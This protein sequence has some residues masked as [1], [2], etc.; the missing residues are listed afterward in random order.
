MHSRALAP[1]AILATAVFAA[2]SGSAAA[3]PSA[4]PPTTRPQL[5]PGLTVIGSPEQA[6]TLPGSAA[7]IATEDIRGQSYADV[8]RVLR[9]VPGV[10]VREE[11][12]FGLFPNVSLRG[13]DTTRNSKLTVME[14]GVLTAP[15]PYA[16][17]AAY[18]SPNI[19]RMSA[20]EIL[21]G[22]SQIR[23]GPHTTGGVIN[24]LSTAI[25]TEP[26][27]YV[28]TLY[29]QRNEVRAHAYGGDTL[30]TPWGHLGLL[31]EGFYRETDGFKHIDL[32][33]DFRDG[34]R[35]GFS[36]GEP[37]LKLAFEPSAGPYQRFEFKIG[38]SDLDADETYLGLSDA[39]FRA[40]SNR[41]YAASRFD[42]IATEHT[43]TYLRHVISPAETIRL[44]T[45]AY[46]NEFARNWFKLHDIAIPN[47]DDEGRTNVSLS[48]AL[49]GAQDGRALAVLKGDAAG[50][51]RVRNND[52]SY[53]LY[54]VENVSEVDVQ[55]G[56]V[57]HAIVAGARFHT[58]RERRFQTDEFFE[59][60]ANGTINERTV[61]TPGAAGNRRE[62]TRALALFMQD[63][64]SIGRLAITPGLRWEHLWL[65]S[66]D[67][68]A[69]RSGKRE[70]D[71]VAGGIGATYDLH[72][73]WRL[74]SGVH[75][76]FSPPDPAA[77]VFDRLDIETSIGT[78]LG[79]RHTHASGTFTAEG[80]GFYT[81]FDDLLVIDNIGGTGTGTSENVGKVDS[82]GVELAT[83]YDLGGAQG[84]R[85]ANPYF[86]NF[87]YTRAVLASDS[88]SKDAESLFAGGK[89]GNHVPYVPEIAF[90]VG[91]SLDFE[92]L[93]L[94]LTGSYLDDVFTTASN[95][96][97]QLDASGNPDARFGKTD[98]AFL[99]DIASQYRV[100][101]NVSLIAGVQ[102]A[103]DKRYIASRHPHGPRPGQ[104][105]FGYG[106]VEVAF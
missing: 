94:S 10:Y 97:R 39:D 21:K 25:P 29:G 35:T 85:F 32:T 101:D 87:T 3:Q 64:F 74:F 80:T 83:V 71:M 70:I 31:V 56:P 45:T 93:S 84:W 49:A 1:V 104:P 54:G 82:Y 98:D 7:F 15:A 40:N 53:Y 43:R 99:V 13:V 79:I 78:E 23:F 55:T 88:N 106:A 73:E 89:K 36:L 72:P 52:R 5:V 67:F 14:D 9:R 34:E 12:G 16:A 62:E 11:D 86:A 68:G 66:Q 63:T 17:P 69:D 19:G 65:D 95:T 75:R 47:L 96:S 91:T 90:T 33:P 92:R 4:A 57:A 102:N 26:T 100:L 24:Y 81:H 28:R 50:R 2:A 48:A 58:D 76:G 77:G 6:Q 46:Y 61:G 42:N 18:Y 51:L 37:M 22:S 59:Q 60:A 38:Y 103:F 44:T 27:A 30:A 20:V 8:N 105:I 41:R